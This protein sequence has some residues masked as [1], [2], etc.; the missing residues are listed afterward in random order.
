[1]TPF[2]LEGTS[3]CLQCEPGRVVGADG[4]LGFPRAV[5]VWAASAQYSRVIHMA[6]CPDAGRVVAATRVLVRLS[7]CSC[8]AAISVMSVAEVVFH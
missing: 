2:V 8:G 4:P 5:D 6:M 1:M 7:V 3:L